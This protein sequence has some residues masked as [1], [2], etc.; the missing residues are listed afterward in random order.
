MD[1]QIGHTISGFSLQNVIS[2][3]SASI[4][5]VQANPLKVEW[6]NQQAELHQ[7][8]SPA[9]SD[10]IDNQKDLSTLLLDYPDAVEVVTSALARFHLHPKSPVSGL[11]KI[12]DNSGRLCWLFYSA[13]VLS[14]TATREPSRISC[15]LLRV[16]D[17]VNSPKTIDEFTRHVN[18]K[19]HKNSIDSLTDRQQ[20]VL[21]LLG[22]GRGRKEIASRLNLSIYTI[23]DHKQAL[24][25]KFNCSSTCQLAS[26]AQR[27]G[28]LE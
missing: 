2:S 10:L 15:I 6:H 9:L 16:N 20:E 12:N 25:R 26:F 7:I 24:Y 21:I 13:K 19:L 28:I 17:L 22:Q 27:I 5:V 4:F 18:H 11:F 23:E 1:T 14:L 8:L 3:I